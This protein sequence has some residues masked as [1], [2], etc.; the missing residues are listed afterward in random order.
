MAEKRISRTEERERAVDLLV[1][2]IKSQKLNFFDE[3]EAIRNLM[4]QFG[5]TQEET[6][7]KLGRVQSTIANKLRLLR[8]TSK[9]RDIIR[10]FH[11]TER[12]ARA[13]LKIGSTEDRM[14]VLD[15]IISEGLR[16]DKTEQLIHEFIGNRNPRPKCR[17][18]P[19]ILHSISAF[20][21][22]LKRHV[23]NMKSAG[24]PV[25]ILESKSGGF[26]EYT[27]K[28]PVTK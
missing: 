16:V 14:I 27:V 22:M 15:R 7:E 11:L 10:Q 1:A 9:E 23:S 4:E 28:I 20:E 18:R 2:G 24:I 6:A 21:K 5:L 12:H 13:L 3:A 17:K 19:D 25:E 8:L 26:I